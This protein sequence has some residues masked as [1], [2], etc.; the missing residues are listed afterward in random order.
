M[1][2]QQMSSSASPQTCEEDQIAHLMLDYDEVED[3]FETIVQISH[4]R[5]ISPRASA[6]G[7]GYNQTELTEYSQKMETPIEPNNFSKGLE[8]LKQDSEN[9]ESP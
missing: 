7:G 4:E 1:C 9:S 5:Q 6:T 8:K 2:R 3:G